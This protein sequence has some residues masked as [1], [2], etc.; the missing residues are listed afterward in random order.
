M[1]WFETSQDQ[2]Y[3]T[4]NIQA[5]RMH[6]KHETDE[7]RS[8]FS[9]KTN[10]NGNFKQQFWTRKE[11]KLIFM[12]IF[13]IFFK[14]VLHHILYLRFHFWSEI[15]FSQLVFHLDAWFES[16]KYPIQKFSLPSPK[17]WT[18]NVTS[19]SLQLRFHRYFVTSKTSAS[20][21]SLGHVGKVSAEQKKVSPQRIKK[22]SGAL[23]MA[24]KLKRLLFST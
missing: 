16:P 11:Q 14:F 15:I 20:L 18:P 2:F 22:F 13:F 10:G 7:K 6:R 3:C 19:S 5:L 1:I 23:E 21:S 12:F 24:S 4:L 9:L 17:F 8:K